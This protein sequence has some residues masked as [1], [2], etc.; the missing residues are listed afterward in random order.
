MTNY[1]RHRQPQYIQS[2]DYR[3][4]V[5]F[6]N[7]ML[8]ENLA[9]GAWRLLVIVSLVMESCLLGPCKVICAEPGGIS[10]QLSRRV[11][12]CPLAA[13]RR[14]VLREFCSG[15]PVGVGGP[16]GISSH[17]LSGSFSAS[18]SISAKGDQPCIAV[19]RWRRTPKSIFTI[20]QMK[21]Q[22]DP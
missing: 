11:C 22:E 19:S 2:E 6:C 20:D 13:G 4:N 1:N 15:V 3:V 5:H 12:T 10:R 14:Q 17:R 9:I 18:A 16:A 8:H 21:Y 7:A